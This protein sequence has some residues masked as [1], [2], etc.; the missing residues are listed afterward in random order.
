MLTM[1]AN[2]QAADA[3]SVEPAIEVRGVTK[4]FFG[5]LVLDRVD[6]SVARGEV[7]GL[8]G[9]NGAG[10]STLLKIF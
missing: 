3:S 1:A 4:A 8:I 2:S 10:K 5:A 7:H 6:F 9:K